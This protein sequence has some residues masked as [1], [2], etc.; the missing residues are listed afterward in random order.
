MMPRMRRTASLSTASSSA[1]DLDGFDHRL[2]AARLRAGHL[3]VEA[4][5]ERLHPVV[6]RAPVGDHQSVEAPLVLEDIHEQRVVL[7]AVRRR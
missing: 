7:G 2:R 3:Q 1:P 4:A 5:L 6:H